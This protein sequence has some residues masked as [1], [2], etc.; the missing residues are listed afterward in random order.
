MLQRFAV[1][2]CLVTLALSGCGSQEPANPLS[3]LPENAMVSVVLTQ[4]VTAVRN[5]D[6]YIA[7]GAPFLGENVVENAAVSYLGIDA[8]DDL[9]ALGFDPQGS[10]VFWMES[11]MPQS[12]AMAV[13]ITDLTAFLSLLERLGLA[14]EPGEPIDK[15]KVFQAPSENGTIFVAESRGVA[16]MAM[17]RNKLSEMSRALETE[18]V[19]EVAPASIHSSV[20]IAMIGPMAASQIPMIAQAAATEADMPAFAGNLM[21]LYFD[22][23]VVVLNQT[24]RAEMTLSFGPETVTAHQTVFFKEDSDLARLVVTPDNPSLLD[25]IPAGQVMS[26]QVRMPPELTGIIMNSV[27]QAMGYSIDPAVADIWTEMGSCAAMSLYSDGFMRFMAVYVMPS[28]QDL[29]GMTA[30]IMDMAARSQSMLPPEM[31]GMLTFSPCET[32]TVDGIEMM[33]SRFTVVIPVE[34]GS[35]DTLALSY[36]FASH[37]GL[38]MVESGD[39]PTAILQTVS[40]NFTPASGMPGLAG[41][42]MFNYA[43]EIGGYLGIIRQFSPEDIDLP[44]TIPTLWVTG[45]VSASDGVMESH[46]EVS[47]AELVNFI[48]SLAMASQQ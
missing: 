27:Y 42:G 3:L 4:P 32:I 28:G 47:G 37:D 26:A 33:N 36:W 10:V 9:A 17:T 30:M 11:M 45:G 41:D 46:T 12:M 14:F 5:M 24:E 35:V 38:F 25:R 2:T 19:R 21:T 40:G 48:G 13:S 6:A 18:A 34:E 15:M 22:A 31:T 1:F 44:E 29:S 16:L 7:S 8:L 43:M 23:A 39:A 20:N